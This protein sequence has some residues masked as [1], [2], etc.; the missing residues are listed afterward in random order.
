MTIDADELA[1]LAAPSP[2]ATDEQLA[3]WRDAVGRGALPDP[4]R[5]R[6]Q[7]LRCGCIN[8]WE[9]EDAEY[10]FADGRAQFIGANQSGK[11]TLMTLTTLIMLAGAIDRQYVD[12]F[13]QS[14]KAFRYYVEPSGDDRDR[15]DTTASINRGWAWVEYGRRL[16]D[17]STE[18]YTTL[19]YA[20]AKRGVAFTPVW[21]ICHGSARV[22]D[23]LTLAV[24]QSAAEPKDLRDVPGFVV[25]DGGRKYAER[26]ATELFGLAD[27]DRFATV[28]EMLKTLRT[29]HLGQRLDPD[30]FTTQ[31]RSALP[32]VARSEVEELA[33]GWQQ[34]QKLGK[35]RDDATR[36][37][38]QIHVYLRGTWRPWADTVLRYA[39]DELLAADAAVAAAD[40]A[41]TAANAI[42]K[43]A[44][45]DHAAKQATL[46]TLERRE[47]ETRSAYTTLL[48]SK[49][50]LDARTRAGNADSLRAIAELA[51]TEQRQAADRLNTAQSR[52]AAAEGERDS[53]KSRLAEAIKLVGEAAQAFIDIA[54]LAGLG[55]QSHSWALAG[56][57]DRLRHAVAFRLGQVGELRKQLRAVEKAN[58]EW[59]KAEAAAAAAHTELRN[60]TDVET[61][62][63]Q[64]LDA[65]LQTL[66]DQLERW[67]DRLG[68]DAPATP[69]RDGWLTAITDRA[70]QP[71]PRQVLRSLI[72]TD[73][74]EP[75]TRPLTE[76]VGSLRQQAQDAE[77]TARDADA[78]ADQQ[79]Q[80]TDPDPVP[81][82]GWTRRARPP[83][84]AAGGAP[85]WRLI[86]P[87]PDVDSDTLDHLEAALTA[88]G[89]TDAW[90]TPDGVHDLGR[91]GHDTVIALTVDSTP[92]RSVLDVFTPAEDAGELTAAVTGILGRIGYASAG[93]PLP[94]PVA[95]CADGRWRTP[96]TSGHAGPAPQGASLIGAAARAAARRRKIRELREQAEAARTRAEQARAAAD[97]IAERITAL[98]AALDDAPDDGDT[99]AAGTALATAISE[100]SK[101]ETRYETLRSAAQQ[102]QR[103]AENTAAEMANYAQQHQLPAQAEPLEDVA[104]ALNT[105]TTRVADLSLALQ[106]RT[107]A[108]RDKASADKTAEEAEADQRRAVKDAHHADSEASR[109][110]AEA[111][112]A[113][114]SLDR[115]TR[116]QLEHGAS[117]ED[118][119][120]KLAPVVAA[121]R[122]DESSA[123]LAVNN[124]HSTAQQAAAAHATAV[125]VR[126][127]ATAAWW[128]PV[129]AGLTDAR[130][131]PPADARGLTTALTQAH[132]AQALRIQNWPDTT[133]D[134]QKRVQTAVTRLLGTP[135]TELRAILET[136]GGRGVDVLDADD[137]RPLPTILITVD[138]AGERLEPDAAIRHLDN[139]I[140]ELSASHD[141]K[142][143]DMY[144]DLLESTFI[145][146]LRERLKQVKQLLNDVNDVLSRH[147]TGANKTRLQLVRKAAEGHQASFSVLEALEKGTIDTEQAQHQVRT[148]L[149]NLLND[150]Q[151][152]GPANND[153]WVDRL[154][155]RLDYRQWFDIVCMF[156]VDGRKE[157]NPLTRKAHSVDSGGGKV[158]TLLQPLL[159]TL[160]ALYS[161][162]PTAPR[163]LWLDE[164]FE[165]VDP[166]NR[167]TMLRMLTDFDLDFL[168]AGPVP[169][170]TTKD[171]PAAAIWI[172]TRAP[173]PEPGVDLSLMLWAGET[174]EPVP[175]GN[176]AAH[177]VRHPDE[178]DAGGPDLFTVLD[179]GQEPA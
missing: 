136:A 53:A 130:N 122:S 60:R 113:A 21:A 13:G 20:Q 80:A 128:V 152:S 157:W 141:K 163:P 44:Q 42:H 43:Q 7:V 59:D 106:R 4:V 178:P 62:A 127:Q 174:L 117:L 151:D 126:D 88:A 120:T 171:V 95:V 110:K 144:A 29:P 19:L 27:A 133:A 153:D 77:K 87:L 39:A 17:N 131:L 107:T 114:A 15:R 139:V 150:T 10:W 34:M 168:L 89:L 82:P 119:L 5:E 166:A 147:P 177:L 73:W 32:P 155:Q 84:P 66:S 175:V 54:E 18:Y 138:A 35:D 101:A 134:K 47:T 86:D 142:L 132:A 3:T 164:A 135:I 161:E 24:R 38:E 94:G 46:Q 98:R 179:D 148:F 78:A 31:I 30:F 176:P 63:Q 69:I 118:Q 72:A 71:N 140:T 68:A 48:K 116:Q 85:L 162:S 16:P 76:Q 40:Q 28:I 156:K 26:I 93:Q 25:C 91:D 124:A 100:R 65:A 154:E 64:A 103:A 75:L 90:V 37:R 165:G 102:K 170:V 55:A 33:D 112:E 160:V 9:F 2:G 83:Y 22:R 97:R 50:Y 109:T 108:E 79:E 158:V 8:L 105:T 146:H 172:I 14:D 96:A 12:T 143:N 99:V 92:A 167:A 121:A 56:D 104:V 67:T 41:L 57:T 52:A 81:Q 173:A 111:D 74:L 23:G 129:D 70:T 169:I 125:A 36:A 58:T 6:W 61:G 1:A 149:D 45:A 51:A 49:S 115:D 123:A 159:A 145:D 137:T 11:S